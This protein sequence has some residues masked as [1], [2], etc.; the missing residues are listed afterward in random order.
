MPT[1][2]TD[3]DAIYRLKTSLIPSICFSGTWRLDMCHLSASVF[4]VR[5]ITVYYSLRIIANAVLCC[6]TQF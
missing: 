1:T 6:E 3:T 2:D 5:T 4:L